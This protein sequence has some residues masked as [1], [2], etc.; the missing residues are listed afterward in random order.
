MAT[1]EATLIQV[2]ILKN[3]L[4]TRAT[5]GTTDTGDYGRIRHDLMKDP[6]ARDRLPRFV[7][8]CRTLSEFWSFIKPKFPSYQ[9]RRQFIASEF[10]P[11]LAKLEAATGNPAV[12]SSSEILTAV[13]SQHVQ[14]AW[15]KAMDRRVSDPDGAI[16]MA[17]SLLETVCKFVL[18]KT[19]VPYNDTFD[20]PK[21]Y[22]KVS[23]Q[24]KLAPSQHSEP[25][26]KQIL[27]GCTSAVE[28]LGAFRNRDGDAH[29]K[30][31]HQVQPKPRHAALAVN[32][33]GSLAAFLVETW[34]ARVVPTTKGA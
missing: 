22:R 23:E 16:T 24:L 8:S 15:R 33:A 18:E 3:L 34:E 25:I 12:D 14:E 10:D 32:L 26:V 1:V 19:G 28:G 11:L 17:R 21:L 9:E 6:L 7:H 4:V 29:G 20:L 30:G 31:K 13:D 27:G 2:E 5:G